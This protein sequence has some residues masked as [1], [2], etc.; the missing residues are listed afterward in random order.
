MRHGCKPLPRFH[1]LRCSL[2]GVLAGDLFGLVLAVLAAW[3]ARRIRFADG[4]RG[5]RQIIRRE[6]PPGSVRMMSRVRA[7][8]ARH[9]AFGKW[10]AAAS[11][12]SAKA[13]PR[14]SGI[15][16]RTLEFPSIPAAG[17]AH[18]IHADDSTDFRA[19]VRS[20]LRGQDVLASDIQQP[21]A[22]GSPGAVNA[23]QL[24][25]PLKAA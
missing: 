18:A 16:P 4:C 15:A 3:L 5:R 13:A 8:L 24:N 21:I 2:R 25:V 19:K 23:Q 20:A 6:W 17:F 10:Q 7:L 22:S 11:G 14:I 1:S 9:R 12:N